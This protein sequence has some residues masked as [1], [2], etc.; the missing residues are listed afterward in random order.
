ME[1]KVLHGFTL[2]ELLVTISIIGI[3]SVLAMAALSFARG[4][5]RIAKAKHDIDTIVTAVKSLEADT[6]E[7]P[8]HQ[9]VDELTVSGSNEI[10]DLSVQ[11]AG[12][13]DTDGLFV[14]WN[15]P[16]MVN[17]PEDP[18]GN[19]YFWDSDYELDGRDHVVIGSFGPNGVGQNLYDSDDIVKVLR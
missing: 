9:D 14:R 16:Y 18:W 15:G 10:W 7:W 1:K 3:L 4:Q 13:T 8:G 17:I 2:V 11:L 12:I 19:E 6:G 5:A